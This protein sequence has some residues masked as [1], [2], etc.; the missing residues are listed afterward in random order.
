VTFLLDYEDGKHAID[1]SWA[2]L[3]SG[4]AETAGRRL[5]SAAILAHPALR[6]RL[7]AGLE[8]EVVPGFIR[9]PATRLQ[10]TL[11]G[12]LRLL[13]SGSLD[14]PRGLDLL[15]SAVDQLPS[16]F[17]WELDITG[18]GPLETQVREFAVQERHKSRVRFHGSMPPEPYEAL[19]ASC[20]VGLNCQKESDPISEVTFP[21]KVF[22]YFSSGLQVLSSRASEVEAVCGR[23]CTYYDGESSHALS[24]AIQALPRVAPPEQI[25]A[26][27]A[28]QGRYSIEGTA[29][30]LRLLLNRSKLI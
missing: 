23:A 28:L 5:I 8:Y 21:S 15:M 30:R 26:L 4:T 7:P 19:L 1:R 13:Y 16:D 9:V 2:R 25:E 29:E 14:R 6:R 24:T 3:L 12:P 10:R 20:H 18:T 27:K 11:T 22:T 17:P